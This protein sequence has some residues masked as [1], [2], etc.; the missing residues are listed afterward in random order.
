MIKNPIEGR[1]NSGLKTLT[2]RDI[3]YC[4]LGLDNSIVIITNHS[5]RSFNLMGHKIENSIYYCSLI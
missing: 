2:S 5:D 4:N 1:F 3:N